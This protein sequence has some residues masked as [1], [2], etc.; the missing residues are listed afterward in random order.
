MD[1]SI[2]RILDADQK[3]K[4]AIEQH[5]QLKI[6]IDE[7]FAAN[8]KKIDEANHEAYEF[9]L[10]RIEREIAD[11]FKKV[12]EELESAN[13]EKRDRII[14]QFADKADEWVQLLVKE[15]MNNAK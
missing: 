9:E 12:D 4:E 1:E 10:K 2:K 8:K 7:E 6:K 14:E 15:T 5:K 13:R 11:A 3:A